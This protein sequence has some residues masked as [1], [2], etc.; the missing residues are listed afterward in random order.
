MTLR[1][2]RTVLSALL[3]ALLAAVAAAP[4]SPAGAAAGAGAAPEREEAARGTF[5]GLH[6]RTVVSNLDIP[7]DVQQLP[8]G[9]LLITERE[10]RKLWVKDGSGKHS[11]TFPN[12]NI[13]AS[14]ETGLMGLAIDPRFGSNRKFYTCH[15][16]TLAGGG[17][18]IA[19]VAW[20]LSDN[21]RSASR[22]K[23]LLGGIQITSGRHGGCRL[24]VRPNGSMY[25]GTGDAAV[26]TNPQRL[27]S[28]NGK[29]LR[30]NYRTG[31]PW[32]RNPFID[33]GNKNRR[34]VLNYGHRNI[35]GLA[36]RADGS[37]W[38]VEHGTNIDDEVNVVVKGGNY[39]WD[40]APDE[41]GDPAYDEVAPMT[42]L[43][44]FP[45]AIE[46]AWSSGPTVATSGAAF[47]RGSRWGEYAGML[48]VACLKDAK[49]I[50]MRINA[51][52]VVVEERI[53]PALQAFGRLRSVTR[54]NNGDLLITTSN[55]F[56]DRVLRVS[57]D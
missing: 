34:Y 41:A 22:V 29:V 21:R 51:S 32:P 36:R 20:R 23:L 7:W 49:V 38:T 44:K 28:L 14:G 48:A 30:L 50:F 55:G 3:C 4:V 12:G 13:W 16:R 57:P 39:G 18:D 47:V 8:G 24:L 11:V 10:S 37:I 35:Q 9:P 56:D 43:V 40:P 26:G 45:D 42:D 25:V 54:A 2:S 33:A 1:G 31:K 15:G 6:V 27:R 19:V 46:A 53:P 17:H 5:P 52:G